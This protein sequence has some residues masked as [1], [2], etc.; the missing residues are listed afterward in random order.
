MNDLLALAM[1]S[2]DQWV[3]TTFQATGNLA[4]S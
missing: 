1:F 2:A 4:E 3:R